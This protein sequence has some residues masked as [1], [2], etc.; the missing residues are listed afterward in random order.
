MPQNAANKTSKRIA[1]GDTLKFHFRNRRALPCTAALR[2]LSDTDNLVLQVQ[3]APA[4]VNEVQTI[5][6]TG[7]TTAGTFTI[8]GDG[9]ITGAITYSST[10]GTLNTNVKAA[11][12]AA[13]T[14]AGLDPNSIRATAT[15]SAANS[16]TIILTFGTAPEVANALPEGQ[17]LNTYHRQEIAPVVVSV[18]GLS[19]GTPAAAVAETTKG[20][21]A[22][23][24]PYTDVDPDGYSAALT[25]VPRGN[26]AVAYGQANAA[27]NLLGPY[28]QVVCT[29]GEGEIEFG[30]ADDAI[31]LQQH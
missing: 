23:S 28:V 19:G 16:A 2:N 20:Y 12:A 27:N 26:I 6:I 21:A 7:T 29:S 5:T 30:F 14:A 25:I 18:A 31:M 1:A 15:A 4:G 17:V 13:L 24:A 11:V 22:G 3:N 8:A 10:V 9:W